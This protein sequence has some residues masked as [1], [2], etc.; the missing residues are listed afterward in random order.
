MCRTKYTKTEIYGPETSSKVPIAVK[1]MFMDKDHQNKVTRKYSIQE[2]FALQ[3]TNNVRIIVEKFE[4]NHAIKTLNMQKLIIDRHG[5]VVAGYT[6]DRAKKLL[7][8]WMNVKALEE[9]LP[10]SKRRIYNVPYYR[11]VSGEYLGFNTP[12]IIEYMLFIHLLMWYESNMLIA[13]RNAKPQLLF[14][15][16][17]TAYNQHASQLNTRLGIPFH[18]ES[19]NGETQMFRYKTNFHLILRRLKERV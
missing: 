13:T 18:L 16:D 3:R 12:K 17:S 9:I 4:A 1:H 8:G 5:V 19:F 10:D 6:C 7:K 2:S 11:N 15:I 14:W